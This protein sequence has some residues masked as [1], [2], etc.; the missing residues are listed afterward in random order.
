MTNPVFAADRIDTWVLNISI[1]IPLVCVA[2]LVLWH[3]VASLAGK[4]VKKRRTGRQA[5]EPLPALHTAKHSPSDRGTIAGV[6]EG[7][8]AKQLAAQSKN[9]PERLERACAALVESLA[10]MYLELAESWL[11]KGQPRHAAAALQKIIQ[12][13]PDTRQAQVAWD[14]LR[15]LGAAENHS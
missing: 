3:L 5:P 13:C 15:G 6:P 14:R 9:D 10:E 11:R 12:S 4:L 7:A 2:G 1:A 8:E